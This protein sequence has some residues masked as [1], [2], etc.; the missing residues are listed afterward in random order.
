MADFRAESRALELLLSCL[1]G[2]LLLGTA[3][4]TQQK[5]GYGDGWVVAA[6]GVWTG[7]WDIFSYPDRRNVRVWGFQRNPAGN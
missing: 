5:I 6:A 7:M 1:P 3:G 4:L 2:A